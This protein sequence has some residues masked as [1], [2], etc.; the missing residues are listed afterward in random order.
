MSKTVFILGA[1]TSADAGAPVMG[2]FL[3][4][5]EELMATSQI[6]G[7]DLEAFQNVFAGIHSL[8]AVFAKSF[9]DARNLE[10]VFT[11]FEMAKVVEKLPRF[12]E[13]D[14]CQK[15]IDD[16]KLVIVRTLELTTQMATSRLA[17]LDPFGRFAKSVHDNAETTSIITFNYD[18][19]IDL[20]LHQAQC[21]I[22]Y[23]LPMRPLGFGSRGIDLC[24]LH[25][26]L[27]WASSEDGEI[28]ILHPHNFPFTKRDGVDAVFSDVSRCALENAQKNFAKLVRPVIVPPTWGKS[29]H[30]AQI[31]NVWKL[32]AKHLSEAEN[33]F[34][35][36]YSLPPTDEFFRNLFALGSIGPARLRRFWVIDRYPSDAMEQRYRHLLGRLAESA[37]KIFPRRFSKFA[38]YLGNGWTNLEELLSK[39]L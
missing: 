27:N 24:K 23:G 25:G 12:E 20:A 5:A 37:F 3:D 22:N 15:L 35:V 10:A 31:A 28:Y 30:Y 39:Q 13:P 17:P 7:L 34:V 11:A 1:G 8:Q 26:S 2:D 21:I 18:C 6:Q 33:I 9:I 19:A 16:L 14:A 32:A 38:S 36:G 4:V 29:L